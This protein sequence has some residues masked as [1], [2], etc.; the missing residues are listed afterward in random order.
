VVVS[1]ELDLATATAL[2]Q[3]LHHSERENL[4]L[5]IDL[6]GLNFIDAVGLAVIYR[7]WRTAEK[8]GRQLTV[9]GCSRQVE[10][11]FTLTGMR[12]LLPFE[13]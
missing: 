12:G 13:D 6:E 10:Q 3:V 8:T 2:D 7:A 4:G 5:C 11:L 1:G 9:R